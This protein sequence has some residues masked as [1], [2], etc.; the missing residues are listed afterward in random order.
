[1]NDKGFTGNLELLA[2][3]EEL[4]KDLGTLLEVEQGLADVQILESKSIYIGTE[5][6]IIIEENGKKIQKTK[7]VWF[8]DVAV[9]PASTSL[10]QNTDGINESTVSYPLTIKGTNLQDSTGSKLYVDENGN[11]RKVF[12]VSCLPGHSSYDTFLDSVP[13]PKAKA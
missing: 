11:T 6:Y 7:K 10:S 12:K 1:M 5:C 13:T 2:R 3:D 8:F 9:A 4:E